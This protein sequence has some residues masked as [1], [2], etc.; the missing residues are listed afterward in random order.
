MV[1]GRLGKAFPSR[2][3]TGPELTFL[4][5]TTDEND[6]TGTDLLGVLAPEATTTTSKQNQR[7]DSLQN[8]K[9]LTNIR[10]E[11]LNKGVKMWQAD[12]L[13]QRS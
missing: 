2:T 8:Q 6:W 4:S 9:W 3:T 12:K 13:R 1:K 5:A 11:C 7:V 10:S